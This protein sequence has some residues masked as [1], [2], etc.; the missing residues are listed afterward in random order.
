ML[1]LSSYAFVVALR[2]LA[3]PAAPL[4]GGSSAETVL[5]GHL[6]HAPAGDT[7][8]LWYGSSKAQTVL[9]PAG[10]FKLVIKDLK[11]ANP[12][13]LQYSRQHTSI[14][15]SPGDQLRI[16]L[17][18]PRFDE[19]LR[20]TGCGADANNYLAQSLYKFEYG[21]AGAV[22]R[23]QEQLTPATTPEQAR[24]SADAFRQQRQ[25][26][27]AAYAKTHPLPAAFQRTAALDIDLEWG[28]NLLDYPAYHHFAA[29]QVAVLPPNYFDFLGQLPLKKLDS[30]VKREPVLRFI[31]SYAGRLLPE[32]QLSADLAAADRLYAQATADFGL[33]RARDQALYQLLSFQLVEGG[34]GAV[35]VAYPTF[36]AQNRDSTLARYMHDQVSQQSRLLPGQPAPAFTLR[37][38]NGQSVSL[39][40]FRGKVVYLDFWAS[41]CRPC[42]AEVP[43]GVE[44]KKQ[45][46]GR[47]VVF[48][49]ISIDRRADDWRKALAMQP[50][51]G[52]S[53]VH[54]LN[55]EAWPKSA[56]ETYQATA[57]PSYWL[58]GRDGRIKRAHAP[59]PSSG[60]EIVAAI[61]SALRE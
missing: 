14:Y 24:R 46:V 51:T 3:G 31:N 28:R 32:G 12:A 61:E 44:L 10:D 49:Y 22:P 13:M 53:S 18:F 34:A 45:F 25:A 2:L 21:P 5:S 19:T 42:M 48:L 38:A 11:D 27:L 39:G 29:K 47:D 58:I 35:L 41:W 50:L 40:D 7:V 26:F 17:D 6:D 30:Q 59:R 9:G 4:P 20:Y 52:P 16:T 37:D 15:L 1:L 54:L 8:R 57:I 43:A 23:P 55:Q 33:T 56:G 60:T 36:R